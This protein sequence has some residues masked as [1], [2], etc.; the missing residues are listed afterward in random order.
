MLAVMYTRQPKSS[1]FF[2]GTKLPGTSTWTSSLH[3]N[4]IKTSTVEGVIG[5]VE[6]QELHRNFIRNNSISQE[7]HR[8]KK[9]IS[10]FKRALTTNL[11][12]LGLYMCSSFFKQKLPFVP[13]LYVGMLHGL[14]NKK[15]CVENR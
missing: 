8:K 14:K 12:S 1:T 13:P 10:P 7:K 5:P 3:R 15:K 9:K 11:S 4:V 2:Q 6:T